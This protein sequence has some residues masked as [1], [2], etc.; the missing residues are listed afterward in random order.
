MKT[1]PNSNV[2]PDFT[3]QGK[4][5]DKIVNLSKDFS[6]FKIK[7]MKEMTQFIKVEGLET[8]V[9][10]LQSESADKISKV[11]QDVENLTKLID[12]QSKVGLNKN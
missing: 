4:L 11:S 9:H 8:I 2:E 6:E 7:V 3:Q 1:K 12:N 5:C 10:K